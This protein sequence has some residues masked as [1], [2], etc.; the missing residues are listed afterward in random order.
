MGNVMTA[1]K[2]ALLELHTTPEELAA[3]TERMDRIAAEG[4]QNSF[5]GMAND[6]GA[7]NDNGPSSTT[8]PPK[9]PRSDK[10]KPRKQAD[11]PAQAG[12]K[13]S[14]EDASRLVDLI[15]TKESRRVAWEAAQALAETRQNE[16][17]DAGCELDVF[18]R[19][20]TA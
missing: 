4:K 18:I 10:G 5:M 2:A 8:K 11:P 3:R 20:N 16:F 9:K 6:G 1:E 19:E 12:G 7:G 17:I 14:K 13:L 15:Q